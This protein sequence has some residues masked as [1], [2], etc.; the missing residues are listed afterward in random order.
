MRL[1]IGEMKALAD[2]HAA[3]PA[4][5]ERWANAAFNLILALRASDLPEAR[6]LHAE[7]KALA[8]THPEEAILQEALRR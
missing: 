8:D 5:R 7:M 6:R 3:E 2:T 1:A 4:L